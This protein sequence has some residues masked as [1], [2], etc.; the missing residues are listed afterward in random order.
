MMS[1]NDNIIQTN[2]TEI[3]KIS[4]SRRTFAFH[5]YQVIPS[6]LCF[7]LLIPF[8]IIAG[9]ARVDIVVTPCKVY[10]QYLTFPAY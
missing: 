3:G 5:W 9:V 2:N 8:P 6:V 1:Q 4:K 10:N 7:S